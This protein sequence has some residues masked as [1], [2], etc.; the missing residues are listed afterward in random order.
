MCH[1]HAKIDT[2]YYLYIIQLGYCICLSCFFYFK[3]TRPPAASSSSLFYS[4]SCS[5]STHVAHT[6]TRFCRAWSFFFGETFGKKNIALQDNLVV[7][8]FFLRLHYNRTKRTRTA[9]L[10][11][12]PP[13]P[14]P[15]N[16]LPPPPLDRTHC[17][18]QFLSNPFPPLS[19][20][21]RHCTGI[22]RSR[23]LRLCPL[24]CFAQLKRRQMPVYCALR[25]REMGRGVWVRVSG[26][27]SFR[28]HKGGGGGDCLRCEREKKESHSNIFS[29][30][31]THTR[32][33]YT[34]PPLFPHS[35]QIRPTPPPHSRLP[36]FPPP[37]L[38]RPL[39][40]SLP[41]LPSLV[42]FP[43]THCLETPFPSSA[44]TSGVC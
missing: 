25:F 39:R 28:R 2:T 1:T 23:F 30:S 15:P 9:T 40:P 24:L 31:H 44:Q 16:F 35:A 18:S 38:S 4:S 6:H 19:L 41:L 7:V 33:R 34:T 43:P 13:P 26:R 22:F 42:H 36:S 5:N 32:A 27:E 12:S 17:L 20:S 14:P 8:V 10:R 29:L 21:L 11:A 37:S 3:N